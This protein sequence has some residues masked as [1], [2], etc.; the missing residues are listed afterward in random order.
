MVTAAVTVGAPVTVSQ[1]EFFLDGISLGVADTAPYGV[2]LGQSSLGSHGIYAVATDSLGRTSTTATNRVTIVVPTGALVGPGGYTNTFTAQPPATDWATL[3]GAGGASDEYDMDA[4]VNATLTASAFTAPVAAS[5]GNPPGAAGTATW[6]YSGYYLQTRPTQVRYVGLLGRF[7]NNTGSNATRLAVSYRFTIADGGMVEESGRGTR[8]YYSLTGLLNS[9]TNLPALNSTESFNGTSVRETSLALNW[10]PGASLYLLWVDDNTSASG[11]SDAANQ[12]DN[13]S[14]RVTQVSV[15][16]LACAV[17]TPANRAAFLSGT[18][19]LA[20]AAVTN[21]TPPY[22]V[23]YFTNRGAA[24]PI[25]ASAGSS[26]T[27]PYNVNLGSVPVGTYRIYAVATDAAGSPARSTS[28]TNAFV[29]ADPMSATLTAPVHEATYEST[30]E[31]MAA[32]TVSGGTA[33]YSVQ[34]YLD[35]VAYGPP[36]TVVPYERNLGA[37]FV[38]DH[39]I[40]AVATDAQ[41]WVSN[42]PANIIHVTGPLGALLIPT[43]GASYS[44]GSSV[45]LRALVGG[46][47]APYTAAFFTNGQLV[48]TLG[49]PP[50]T[51]NLGLLPVGSYTGLVHVADSS[52]P[53]AQQA[54]STPNVFT[55]LDNPLT[56][57][58]TRPVHGQGVT[59]DQQLSLAATAAVGA[60]LTVSWVEFFMDGVSV[61]VDSAAPYQGFV[62]PVE[63]T[64]LV[65]ATATDSLGRTTYSATNAVTATTPL[66]GSNNHFTN[67]I[68]LSGLIST[69]TG[70]NLSA[71]KEPGEPNHAGYDGGA[72][73]WWRW[74]APESGATTVDTFGS[75]FDTILGVYVG[76]A[77]SQLTTIAGNDDYSGVQS[78]VQ[79]NAVAG[80][81]YRIA[82]DGFGNSRGDIVLHIRGSAVTVSSPAEGAVFTVG[83]PIPFVAGLSPSLPNPVTRVDFYRGGSRFA[84]ISNAPFTAVTTNSPLGTNSF[85]VIAFDSASQSYTS[86]PVNVFVQNVGVTLLLPRDGS[87]FSST[88]PITVT[89][90]AYLPAGFITRIEF[91]VDGQKF[92]EASTAPFSAVWSTVSGGSHRLTAIGWSDTG[93][94]Y[95]SQPVNIGVYRDLVPVVSVWKYLDD[96]SDQGTNWV[97]PAFDDRS[98]AAGSAPLGYGDSGGRWPATTNAFGPDPNNRYLTTYYRQ[99]FVVTNV[100]SYLAFY[101]YVQRDDGVVVYLNGAEVFRNN[102]PSGPVTST[103]PASSTAGD[104]GL[105][106]YGV[107]LNPSSLVEGTNVLAAEVH[108]DGPQGTDSWFRLQLFGMPTIVRN[109]P[110]LVALTNPTNHQ[111]FLAPSSLALEATAS[112]LDGSVIKVEFF[113]DQVKLGQDFTSP[114]T[115]DW[116][117]PPMGLHE[118]RAVATD[119]QGATN[120]SA[121]VNIVVFDAAGTPWA[122][123]VSPAD[124]T[125]LEGPTNLT[126]TASAS[127]LDGMAHVE[128]YAGSDLIG[129]SFG[130][131][132]GAL[133]ADYRFQESLASAVGTAPDLAN[134]GANTFVPAT[135]DGTSRFVL[136]FAENDGLMLSPASSVFANDVF[137]AVVLFSFDTVSSWR[138]LIDFKDAASDYGLYV[139]NGSLSFYPIVVESADSIPANTFVQVALTR[140]ESAR[141][142]GYVEGVE[143]FAFIDSG[144]DA[145]LA[146][147]DV[148]RFFRDNG[149]EGSAGAVARLRLYDAALSATEV[150][151][152][153]RLP[154]AGPVGTYTVLWTNAP[155]GVHALSVVAVDIHGARGTSAVSPSRSPFRRRTRSRPPIAAQVP[156]PA[157]PSP[158]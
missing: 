77:V 17:T 25:F 66:P 51:T 22:T 68:L 76:E 82:V 105:S 118:L 19:I 72:S 53:T 2:A 3:G 32:A 156:R 141:V 58:L 62:W 115:F 114:Y 11:T 85:Y 158:T 33:P 50:F 20:A 128:F 39:T 65:Y 38:G 104:D 143:Q 81:V 123:L 8:V 5:S 124:G 21:G 116:S 14:L 144:N 73:V 7:I 101:A 138:R 99:A 132:A 111:S 69:A 60:P 150:A 90:W 149:T 16:P 130:Q 44:F 126:L 113:A 43:N 129:M 119:N 117:A 41:G 75:S 59:S 64:H 6:S 136:R 55:I 133:K 27:A 56:V 131:A 147:S 120:V 23:E 94:A 54:D 46:G 139:F 125:S 151:A 74:I 153:N 49:A 45:T 97:T 80:T 152:L 106:T 127:A 142:T 78:R 37:L 1:V 87:Y 83:E 24:D 137:T 146:P 135:V 100:T 30:N 134:L 48:G 103:T 63:G 47:T 108:Q 88:S 26:G 35:D 145:G 40:R 31:V 86:A 18:P 42:S 98:W 71:D 67:A 157:R 121:R 10:V 110:P 155:F 84:S 109:Q 140:D 122:R 28:R 15:P 70:L 95:D 79:F 96:G 112:D 92:G 89:A 52:T 36:A 57:N 34:F 93:A 61:G 9:W 4:E 154:Y 148:L 102:M 29:V 13:F 107:Y 12:I 91:F